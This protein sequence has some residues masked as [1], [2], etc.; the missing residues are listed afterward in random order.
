MKK[1]KIKTEMLRRN[2]SVVDHSAIGGLSTNP[3]SV[4]FEVMTDMFRHNLDIM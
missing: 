2:G 3:H 1:L 4:I